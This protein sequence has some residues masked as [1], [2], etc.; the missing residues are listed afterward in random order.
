MSEIKNIMS[1][2]ASINV[3]YIPRF[4]AFCSSSACRMEGK[5]IAG[6]IGTSNAFTVAVTGVVAVAAFIVAVT[7]VVAVAA[8]TVAVTGVV[9]VGASNDNDG[10]SGS[11][12][13]IRSD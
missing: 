2:L 13:A 8:F 3:P 9:A 7:G 6:P 12:R 5:L 1:I 10:G 11:D 4:K